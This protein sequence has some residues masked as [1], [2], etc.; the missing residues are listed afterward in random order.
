MKRCLSILICTL[1]LLSF[2]GCSTAPE[3]NIVATTLPVY[4]FTSRLCNGTDIT[5]SQ[6]ISEPV[7]CLHDYTLQVDQMQAITNADMIILS[8]AGLEDFMADALAASI[9]MVDASSGIALHHEHHHDHGHDADP[10]I[11]LSPANAKVMVQN[12]CRSLCDKYP[13]HK[14]TFLGN[15][16]KLLADLD[17]L[18][19]CGEASLAQLNCRKLITFHDGFG[20]FAESFDLHILKAVEEESGSEASALTLIDLIELVQSNKLPAVFTEINGAE[21]A[22]QIIANETGVKI[23]DLDMA[24]SGNSYFDSMYRNIKTIEEALQ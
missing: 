6:L 20:Y 10:H 7:S 24:M 17:Q 4:E 9:Q 15:Q 3:S 14:T 11:W 2:H 13:Q 1:L 23:Y 22:A 5:V 8:G 12:I 18:Q 16:N 19:A 21:S